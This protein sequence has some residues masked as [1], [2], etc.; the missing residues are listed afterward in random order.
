MIKKAIAVAGVAFMLTAAGAAFAQTTTMSPSPT[1]WVTP[2]PSESQNGTQVGVGGSPGNA[3]SMPS[4]A[5]NTGLGG[6]SK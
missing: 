6:T 5:P 1:T 4:G 2:S 3:N